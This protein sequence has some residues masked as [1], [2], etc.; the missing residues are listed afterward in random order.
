MPH[1]CARPIAQHVTH[2]S[3]SAPPRKLKEICAVHLK[4]AHST[5]TTRRAERRSWQLAGTDESKRW[6]GLAL[7]VALHK[8]SVPLVACLIG[9]AAEAQH[10]LAELLFDV[11]LLKFDPDSVEGRLWA[12]FE[13][14]PEE[15]AKAR[16][17]GDRLERLGSVKQPAPWQKILEALVDG[18]SYHMEARRQEAVSNGCRE[19]PTWTDLT[20]W[21][22][23]IGEPELAHLLWRQ[24][25]T[26]LR[27]AVLAT[28]ASALSTC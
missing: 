16:T 11:K 28:Q 21:A 7:E 5:L 25:R 17:S 1:V 13:G 3:A 24:S 18:Y 4:S 26:P 2:G 8:R 22:A 6:K 12:V 14:L 20:L 23:L 27:T 10:V 9:F 19:R 15:K